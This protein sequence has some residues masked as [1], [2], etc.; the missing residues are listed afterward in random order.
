MSARLIKASWQCRYSGVEVPDGLWAHA[1]I[2]VGKPYADSQADS[3]GSEP[4]M[5][6]TFDEWVR[7]FVEHVGT[8]G[9]VQGADDAARGAKSTTQ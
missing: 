9:I 1:D 8:K 4:A 5:V 7:R 3:L 2:G 6:A